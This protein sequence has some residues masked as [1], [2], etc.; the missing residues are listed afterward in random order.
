VPRW[1][2]G[3]VGSHAGAYLH[4]TTPGRSSAIHGTSR[5]GFGSTGAG[6]ASGS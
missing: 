3:G 6:H 2:Y 1:R 5:G 4:S